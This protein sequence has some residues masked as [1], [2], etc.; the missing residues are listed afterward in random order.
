[1]ICC[2]ASG[3]SLT[4]EDCELVRLSGIET[5]AVNNSWQ[6]AQFADHIYAGDRKWWDQYGAEIDIP[7]KKWTCSKGAAVAHGINYHR[8]SGPYNS[9]MRAIQWAID[10]GKKKIILIGYDCSVKNGTHWH[11]D[12]EKTRNPDEKRCQKWK[13]QFEL[14][15]RLAVSK[16]VEIINCSRHTELL[17]FKRLPLEIVIGGIGGN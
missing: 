6:M 11:G 12:H 14:I 2:I 5:I 17:C 10:S 1:M 15:G 13:K 8:A 16:N 4:F 3:P 9:G 7:A